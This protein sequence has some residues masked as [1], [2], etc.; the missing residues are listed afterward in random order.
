MFLRL[1]EINKERALQAVCWGPGG[2]S[3]LVSGGLVSE[4]GS[5]G[6]AGFFGSCGNPLL[7]A[8]NYNRTNYE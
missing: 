7:L 6:R 4:I 5:F 2:R 8:E 1:L 3:G